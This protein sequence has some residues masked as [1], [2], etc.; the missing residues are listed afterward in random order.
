MPAPQS[1]RV[2]VIGSGVAG[3]TAAHV[4]SA[5][6]SVTLYEADD[7]LGGHADTH[8]VDAP[9]PRAARHRHRLHRAQRA[10]LPDAAAALRRA[11]RRDPGVRHVDVGARR[12]DRPGVGRRA[13]AARGLPDLAQPALRPRYLRMLT[14]IPRFHRRARALLA[15][16]ERD[17]DGTA[18]RPCGSSCAPAASRRTSPATSWSRSSPRSGPCD[19]DLALDYPARYLFTF[20][21]HHGMLGIFGSPQ[22]RTVTGGSR[23]YVARLAAGL[24]DVRTGTKVT[25]VLETADGVEVT[26][27]NGEV[28]T[29]DAVVVATHPGQALAMLAE[30][31]PVQ[32]EVLGALPYSRQHRAAAHR[33]PAAAAAPSA[34][35]RRGTSAARPGPGGQVTVTYDL[36][37]LQRLDTE[38]RY[39]V[40]LG[41]E[42]LVDPAT[43]IARMEYEHPLYT[44]ASVAAQRRL[45]EIAT[46][47]IAFAGAYHGWGFHEDGARSGAGRRRAPRAELAGAVPP[48]PAPRSRTSGAAAGSTGRRSGTPAARRSG[49]PSST[50]R[51][52]GWSTSTTCP[53]TGRWARSRP[54]T[55]SA[56]RTARSAPT[57]R[58][59]SPGRAS[60][61]SGRPDPDGRAR[62]GR[63]ATASTRSACSGASTADGARSPPWSRCTTPTAT[64]TPTSSTPTSRAAR[65]T[66]K[67]MYVSPFHGTDG[68]YELAVPVPGDR[69][70][71]A[72]TLRTDDGAVF[73][74][75]LAGTRTDDGPV[76]RRAGRPAR[77]APHPRPRH[78]AVGPPPARPAPAARTTRKVCPDDPRP[79]PPLGRRP[80]PGWTPSRPG[81]AP[82][83]PRPVARRLFRAAVNRLD[84]TVVLVTD[85]R[86]RTRTLGRGGPVMTVHR[87]DEFFA[88][89]GRDQLIGFG[90]A[91]LTGAWDAEDLAGFL[92]VLAAE[93]PHAGPRACSGCGPP[94]CTGRRTAQRQHRAQHAQQHRAPLRPVQRPVRA[95]P[96]PDAELLLGA[97]RRRGRGPRRPPRRRRADRHRRPRRRRRPARSSGCS[98]RPASARA[99][100]CSRSAP[101]GASW[102]SAP[103]AAARPCTRS[104][105]RASSRRWPASGS[106]PPG[107]PTGSR[108]SSATTA[109]SRPARRRQ[110]DAVVSVE[111]IEAVGHEYWPTYFATI[112]RVLAPGGRVAHPG[113][114]DAARP[115]AGHPQHLHLDQQVHLP[116]RLPALGR[117][118]STR[119]PASTPRCG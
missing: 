10:H 104:R 76:A 63:S 50:P 100:G 71:I 52:P 27:G 108:S 102:R 98:T 115:D 68:T 12:R 106:P 65:R 117:G 37:R 92:T 31:T 20:L 48:P 14:E 72:V 53:T 28:T 6:A 80:G 42:D 109:R 91:Y 38:T 46:D 9:R 82:R 73:S 39:L 87:P 3:L 22:W 8:L 23:E 96:R 25:S 16:G 78:L 34:P 24:A 44:P 97:V 56:T 111:M 49:G 101:A 2:A 54:A 77:H 95:V 75:S 30:P 59:S 90:E 107:S 29:Y 84:V 112:D 60:T 26:D 17:G 5:S 1:R 69:L 74:A 89:L 88:R 81:P 66:A 103:P 11:R 86:G 55:T 51:G 36:T 70:D 57:S 114:H 40:T 83:S 43:V 119:S 118:R 41:G 13:R 113:D 116:R 64:G 7:R 62:R 94:S 4:A 18:T 19:P 85:E 99:P 93:L 47:R 35:G 105:C 33:H 45:P 79:R 21:D 61:S 110:Y 58:R 15:A 67:Q 32:R